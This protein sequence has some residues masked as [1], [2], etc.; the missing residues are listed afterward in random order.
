MRAETIFKQKGPSRNKKELRVNKISNTFHR[1]Y[2]NF[3]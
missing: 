3:D 1:K 2:E